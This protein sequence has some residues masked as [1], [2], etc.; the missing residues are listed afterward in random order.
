MWQRKGKKPRVADSFLM[1][2]WKD[3]NISVQS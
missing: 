2:P 3:Q 1:K